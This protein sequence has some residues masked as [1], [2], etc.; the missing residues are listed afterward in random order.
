MADSGAVLTA[1]GP[2]PSASAGRLLHV[3][4]YRGGAGERERAGLD[5]VPTARAGTGP[6]RVAPVGDAES[7]GGAGGKCRGAGTADRDTDPRR[8]RSHALTAPPGRR[9][10]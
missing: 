8:A 6:N 1:Y 10:G 9:H 4:R 7:D 5:L 3:G 2:P